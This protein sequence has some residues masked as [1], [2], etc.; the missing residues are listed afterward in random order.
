[1]N[2]SQV[3]VSTNGLTATQITFKSPV[4]LRAGY[5]YALSIIPDGASPNYTIWTA[6]VGSTDINTN[7]AITRN[8]GQGV[9]FSSS[10]GST[11][12]PIQN[13]YLKMDAYIA[14]FTGTNGTAVLTNDDYEFFTVQN[15]T[16]YFTQ[17]EW[18]YQQT[19]N[20]SGTI[21]IN[22]TS[23]TVTGTGT[24]FSIGM[25]GNPIAVTNG[26]VSDV[27]IVASVAN[28]TSLITKN[29]PDF[30]S[31][32][33]VYQLAPCG[34]VY[35]FNGNLYKLVLSNS[36]A[37]AAAYFTANS[38]LIGAQSN[39][40]SVITSVDNFIVNKFQPQIYYTTVHGTDVTLSLSGIDS[41]YNSIASKNYN[42]VA[43]NYVNSNEQVIASKTNEI[44]YN[45]GNKSLS[46]SIPVTTN[47]SIISPTIDMQSSSLLSYHNIINSNN[48]NENTRNG[49]AWTK[50]VSNITTLA[51]GQ[52]AED[53]IVY[54]SAYRPPG[55][56]VQLYAKVLNSS[57]GD[58]FSSKDW[59]QLQLVSNTNVYSDLANL[60]NLVEYQYTFADSPPSVSLSGVLSINTS[61]NTI[62]GS[63]TTFTTDLTANTNVIKIWSDSTKTTFQVARVT[64]IASNTSLTIDST[65]AFNSSVA[66][67]E[68]VTQPRTAFHNPQNNGKVRY[69]N[70]SGSAYDT[71]R[72][73]AIKTVLLSNTSYNV[74]R[75]MDMRAIALSV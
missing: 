47:S 26:S 19:A 53:M 39:T 50:G 73:F 17:G 12:T 38:V 28:S 69:Y 25:V 11:W 2:A 52:D 44:L 13:E 4:F 65:G 64:A 60:S 1:L 56:D 16:S 5:E 62:T 46:V 66:I 6:T 68:S 72:T 18:V 32:S 61:S 67:Y 34:K 24:S 31:A 59:S 49:S 42:F 3:N 43:M 55:T 48:T 37:N 8:W 14:N 57:D 27:L 29:K 71:Y 58:L 33:A 74:P 54:I 9:L 35:Y 40:Q 70:S 51:E 15:T 75:V 22:T 21:S 36:T 10:T 7:A 45:S 20:A 63:G 30:A 23:T 41:S